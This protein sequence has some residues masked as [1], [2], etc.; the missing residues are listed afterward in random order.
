M[1]WSTNRTT[2]T[3]AMTAAGYKLMPNAEEPEDLKKWNHKGYSCRL[4]DVDDLAYLSANNIQF[5]HKVLLRVL[6]KHAD[7][8]KLATAEN[9]YT[10][11]IK[12]IGAL[13][14]FKNFTRTD[15]EP[16]DNKHSVANLEFHFG[17]DST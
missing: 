17:L 2:L 3:T 7:N 12:T 15:W 6:F 1:A 16:L 4:Q 14:D 8:T 13:A 5:S 11:L 9:D 10:T